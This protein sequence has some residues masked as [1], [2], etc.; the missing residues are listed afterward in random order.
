MAAAEIRLFTLKG[1]RE[2]TSVVIMS[3]SLLVLEAVGRLRY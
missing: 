2:G 1:G 3:D